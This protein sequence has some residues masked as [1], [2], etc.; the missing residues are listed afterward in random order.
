M[1]P[2]RAGPECTCRYNGDNYRIGEMACIRGELA[3]CDMVTNN[4]S[5]TVIGDSCPVVRAPG[6]VQPA[7][8]SV[9]ALAK[10]FAPR[11]A[12]APPISP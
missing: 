8:R 3:R 10:T 11:P 4:T 6:A 1:A 9:A 5:W 7:R 2:A 12:D